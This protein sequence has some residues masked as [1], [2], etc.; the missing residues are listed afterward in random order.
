MNLRYETY[1]GGS[2]SEVIRPEYGVD[3]S[4]FEDRDKHKAE[5]DEGGKEEE[6]SEGEKQ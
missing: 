4:E 6:D 1:K 3:D 5:E 2:A